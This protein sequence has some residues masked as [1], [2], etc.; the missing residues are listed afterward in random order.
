MKKEAAVF[1]PKCMGFVNSR[2]E[3]RSEIIRVKGIDIE[4]SSPV[5]ICNQ[6]GE[7]LFDR[8]LDNDKLLLAYKAYREQM[9][10]LQPEEIKAI[11]EQYHLSQVAFAKVLGLGDKTIARYE[12]GSLQD[13]AQNNLILLMRNPENFNRLLWHNK[14]K[15]SEKDFKTACQAY[16]PAELDH[17]SYSYQGGDEC[18]DWTWT[19]SFACA[20]A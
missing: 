3:T 17:Q 6:C 10:L 12:S 8:D 18:S 13:E 11:R 9:Q 16:E 15:I 4:V 2:T 14:E 1:C 19:S 20:L 7:I 5:R